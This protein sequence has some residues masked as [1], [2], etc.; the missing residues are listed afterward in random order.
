[1]GPGIALGARS[2]HAG[3]GQASGGGCDPCPCPV[4]ACR[5]LGF[6]HASF[7]GQQFVLERGEYPCCGA[8]S[9]NTAYPVDRLTSFRPV[10]C[11][12]SPTPV[13][14]GTLGNWASRVQL[15]CP[16]FK[17]V[18]Q[19]VTLSDPQSLHLEMGGQCPGPGE[20][21]TVLARLHSDLSVLT[22][23]PACCGGQGDAG[24]KQLS[25]T[26]PSP[27]GTVR[28]PPWR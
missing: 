19:A 16:R 27:L 28:T 18:T 6:E 3:P 23:S 24:R 20:E 2:S 13:P 11:A 12:V 21:D 1:V 8:W 14:Q 9:G 17:C 5:W 7:Q 22:G 10:A 25:R 15:S 4:P 26:C